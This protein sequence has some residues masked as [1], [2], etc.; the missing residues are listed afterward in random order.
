L[1]NANELRFLKITKFGDLELGNKFAWKVSEFFDFWRRLSY[2][3]FGGFRGILRYYLSDQF[4]GNKNLEK[5]PARSQKSSNKS[6]LTKAND[7]E[8]MSTVWVAIERLIYQ[9]SI[10]LFPFYYGNYEGDFPI[11]LK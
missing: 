9:I 8:M 5:F 7:R 6:R 2:W 10:K 1:G 11:F 4:N 3:I